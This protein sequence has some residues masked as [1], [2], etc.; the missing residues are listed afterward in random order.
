VNFTGVA[1]PVLA[2]MIVSVS[3]RKQNDTC[4]MRGKNALI[5]LQKKYPNF[6]LGPRYNRDN[7]DPEKGSGQEYLF[8]TNEDKKSTKRAKF[9]A[10]NPL[11]EGVLS[12][13]IQKG[14]LVY[15]LNYTS[16]AA[17]DPEIK[18]ISDLVGEAVVK[19]VSQKYSNYYEL[20]QSSGAALVV[21]FDE[22]T[23]GKQQF[24][25][26]IFECAEIAVQKLLENKK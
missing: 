16:E 26:A 25:K 13:Y 17:T 10:V 15:G 11:E 3:L 7:Y 9:I 12:L 1:I 21:D 8:I 20:L 14:T 18:R 6:L 22:N 23:M 5:V 19:Y 4:L 24:R 2:V